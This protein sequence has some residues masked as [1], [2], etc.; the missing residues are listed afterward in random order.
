MLSRGKLLLIALLMF[1][2]PADGTAGIS[3]AEQLS[4]SLGHAD[5]SSEPHT[6]F[7]GLYNA[8]TALEKL[9]SA[10]SGI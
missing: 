2:P 4:C 6:G 5:S 9:F 10:A 1:W 8:G 3:S 7:L